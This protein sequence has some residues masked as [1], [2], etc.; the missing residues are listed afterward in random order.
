MYSHV[1]VDDSVIDEVSEALP[2]IKLDP[3][4]SV[5]ARILLASLL[6]VYIRTIDELINK[7]GAEV[8]EKKN[9]RITTGPTYI[10]FRMGPTGPTIIYISKTP[11]SRPWLRTP[12]NLSHPEHPYQ[13]GRW[14][15][16]DEKFSSWQMLEALRIHERAHLD[17]RP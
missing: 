8:E 17:D 15:A 10:S 12:G 5:N 14:E 11:C 2:A 13:E 7:S 3:E 1:S 4:D 9:H 6:L 16:G